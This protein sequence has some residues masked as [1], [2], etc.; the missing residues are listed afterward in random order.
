M[1][2]KEMIKEFQILV[3]E[4][5]GQNLSDSEAFEIANQITA[6]Y[7]ALKKLKL[8][9]LKNPNSLLQYKRIPN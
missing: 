8:Q 9:T 7:K 4:E 6:H 2:S 3:K 1:L 5:Y